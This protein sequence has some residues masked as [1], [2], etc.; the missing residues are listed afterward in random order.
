ME[1]LHAVLLTEKPYSLLYCWNRCQSIALSQP[2][3]ICLRVVKL[4]K[5]LFSSDNKGARPSHILLCGDE[6]IDAVCQ[7]G[8][9]S[10]RTVH[11]KVKQKK[12]MRHKYIL[13]IKMYKLSKLHVIKNF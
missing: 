3:P 8:I 11:D 9:P 4:G 5:E 7:V 13:L 10:F 2:T 6:A 12:K 1:S